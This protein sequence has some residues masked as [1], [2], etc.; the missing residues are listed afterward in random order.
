MDLPEEWSEFKIVEASPG[1][2]TG[3]IK[4]NKPVSDSWN[5]EYDEQRLRLADYTRSFLEEHL[6]M[7]IERLYHE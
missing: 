5:S 1:V 3:Q 4:S 2:F 6:G 7:E